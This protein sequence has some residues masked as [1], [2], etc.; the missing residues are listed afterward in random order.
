MAKKRLLVVDDE[1]GFLEIVKD[2]FTSQGYEVIT[3]SNV[4]EA[5]KNFSRYLPKVVLLDF[6]LPIISGEKILPLFQSVQPTVRVIVLTGCIGEEVEERF[7]GLGYF[8][9]FEKSGLKL[10]NVR[11]K[12]EEAFNY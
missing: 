12:V 9:Y 11:N 10:E 3:A 5:L 7:K 8:A 1:E 2:Y 4:D 6:N